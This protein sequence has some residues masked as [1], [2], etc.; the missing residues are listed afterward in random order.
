MLKKK[1][2]RNKNQA[3][4]KYRN[5]KFKRGRIRTSNEH[6]LYNGGAAFNIQVWFCLYYWEMV[7][8]GPKKLL[9]EVGYKQPIR[10]RDGQAMLDFLNEVQIVA[11]KF[12][13]LLDDYDEIHEERKR[14]GLRQ[15]SMAV[16]KGYEEY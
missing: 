8:T 5:P 3:F 2:P 1:P 14:K 6:Y 12:P 11:N 15:C 9:D 16:S 4:N 13:E 10:W 7:L